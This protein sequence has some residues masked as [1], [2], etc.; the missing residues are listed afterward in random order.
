M[1]LRYLPN[2]FANKYTKVIAIIFNLIQVNEAIFDC[3]NKSPQNPNWHL[4]FIK[5]QWQSQFY[6]IFH[7][8]QSEC[9]DKQS[10]IELGA[11]GHKYKFRQYICLIKKF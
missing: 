4:D 6:E 7:V 5:Y 3:W 10:I 1:C 2:N 11:S 8:R 9:I